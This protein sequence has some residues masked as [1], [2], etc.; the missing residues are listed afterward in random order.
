MSET[1]V[2]ERGSTSDNKFATAEKSDEANRESERT[3]RLSAV[4]GRTGTK[5]IYTYDFGDSWEHSIV[6]EKQLPAD[7]TRLIPSAPMA[8][9]PVRSKTAAVSRDFMTSRRPRRSNQ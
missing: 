7:Q 9:S 6:V 4:L 1:V 5:M 3:E 8:N 2:C